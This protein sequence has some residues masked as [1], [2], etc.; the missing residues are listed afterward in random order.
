[1]KRR[2]ASRLA[3]ALWTIA[4]VFAALMVALMVLSREVPVENR[5]RPPLWF[6][7]VMCLMLLSFSTV[8]ALVASSRPRNAV[9]WIFCGVA[10]SAGIGFSAQFYADYVLIAEPDSL[11]GGAVAVWLNLWTIVPVLTGLTIFALV[12]PEGTFLSPRWRPAAWL[13]VAGGLAILA[14]IALDPGAIDDRNYPGVSNPVGVARADNGL[15][16]LMTIGTLVAFLALAL[17]VV[18]M[19]LR[20]RRSTG[21]ERQQLKWI[22][23]SGAVCAVVFVITLPITVSP[24]DDVA[25]VIAFLSLI[26]VPVATGIAILRYRLYDIDV[27]INRTLVYGSVTALLAGS[28]LG[29]VLLLQLV[30]RPL[31]EEN[32]LAVALSTLAVAALFRPARNRVQELVD[33]RFYR[34]KYDAQQTLE[35]FAAR[36]RD[37]VDLDALRAELTAVV[38]DTMQPAHVSLWLREAPE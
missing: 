31:T 22:V 5:D 9:G 17:A 14:A 8:G 16:A 29:L 35:G 23:Y 20:F 6:V 13:A 3:W 1:M 19:S 33:R 28:Y 18:S 7:P 34:R 21:I 15:E 25:F 12:I 24:W 4:L 2:T 27:V 36:L 37:E 30:F 38:G 26:G 11:P 32:S 10:I